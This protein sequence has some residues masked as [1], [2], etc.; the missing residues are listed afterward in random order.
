MPSPGRVADSG[1]VR[2]LTEALGPRASKQEKCRTLKQW[3]KQAREAR[4]YKRA[5]RIKKTQ[6][7]LGCRKHR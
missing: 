7:A 6:K 1:I 2:E 3:Y 5:E 4:D